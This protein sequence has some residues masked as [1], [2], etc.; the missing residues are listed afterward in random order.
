M[1]SEPTEPSPSY[2]KVATAAITAAYYLNIAPA[3]PLQTLQLPGLLPSPDGERWIR[4]E[5]NLVL[6][7]GGATTKVDDGGNVV[8]ER[9][10]TNYKKNSSGLTDPSY[11]DVE[12]IYTLGYLRYTLR[13]RIAQVYPRCGLV[14]DETVIPAGKDSITQPKAIKAEIVSLAQDWVNDGLIEDLE[15]FKKDLIIER[16]SKEVCRINAR[17]PANLVNQ[18]RIFAAQIQFIL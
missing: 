2:L 18:F 6:T 13:A 8:I 16:D 12:T 1:T 5:R 15:S 4:E 10:V 11:R 14:G 17:L 9:T 3:R 7:Y